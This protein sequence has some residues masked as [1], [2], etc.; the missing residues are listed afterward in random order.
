M[1]EERA[2]APGRL[3]ERVPHRGRASTKRGQRR[4]SDMCASLAGDRLAAFGCF[5][6]F[7]TM[8]CDWHLCV[9][10]RAPCFEKNGARL[11]ELA[12]TSSLP[13]SPHHVPEA[14][15]RGR[16]RMLVQWSSRRAVAVISSRRS[17][18]TQDRP[19]S[20]PRDADSAARAM[21]REPRASAAP[22]SARSAGPCR[23][24][25]PASGTRTPS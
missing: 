2:R 11:E 12:T 25:T 18:D 9:L 14:D 15:G 20:A 13:S 8:R 19:R 7:L 24:P 21:R 23:C 22:R 16:T 10:P 17:A 5:L 4:E 3:T 1:R 6:S